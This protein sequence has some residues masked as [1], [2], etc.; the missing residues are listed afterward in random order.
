MP[1]TSHRLGDLSNVGFE[2]ISLR[3]T[4]APIDVE[5]CGPSFS[6]GLMLIEGTMAVADNPIELDH[7]DKRTHCRNAEQLIAIGSNRNKWANQDQR[8]LDKH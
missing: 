4:N 5:V 6:R 7:H 3:A 1:N 8:K 2:R